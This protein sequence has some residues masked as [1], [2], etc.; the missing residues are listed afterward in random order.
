MYEL[1]LADLWYDEDLTFEQKR[2][3]IVARIGAATWYNESD[4]E[5][6]WIYQSLQISKNVPQ[7]SLSW[8]PFMA[9]ARKHNIRVRT[10]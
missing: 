5:L 9:Y 1:D 10:F 4:F 6:D 2:D 8:N 7:F 3:A